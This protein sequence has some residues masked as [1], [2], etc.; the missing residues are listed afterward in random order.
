MAQS[1]RQRKA[2][3]RDKREAKKFFTTTAIVTGL[4]L[5]LLYFIYAGSN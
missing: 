4:L 5:V 1:K 3:A 2:E